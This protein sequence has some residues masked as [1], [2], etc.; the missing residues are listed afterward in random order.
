MC[1]EL[2]SKQALH[3]NIE[4]CDDCCINILT[5]SI[6]MQTTDCACGVLFKC[7][8]FTLFPKSAI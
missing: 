1:S 8:H 2:L 3:E 7:Q 6:H 4:Q 5:N